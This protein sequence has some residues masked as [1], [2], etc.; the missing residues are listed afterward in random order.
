M[1]TV[2]NPMANANATEKREGIYIKK[3]KNIRVKADVCESEGE[4][5][6]ELKRIVELEMLCAA[7]N[8]N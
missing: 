8:K 7:R 5:R 6:L 4:R 3:K 2:N 1:V